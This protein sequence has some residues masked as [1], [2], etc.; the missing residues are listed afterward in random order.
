MP[1]FPGASAVSSMLSVPR[2]GNL[3]SPDPKGAGSRV[4]QLPC[5]EGTGSPMCTVVLA[6]EDARATWEEA[7][8]LS[9]QQGGE[10]LVALRGRGAVVGGDSPTSAP[11]LPKLPPLLL[12]PFWRC[13]LPNCIL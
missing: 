5:K 8:H 1:V 3:G 9:P 7:L 4:S 13:V 6:S 11:V 12:K 10:T 2:T